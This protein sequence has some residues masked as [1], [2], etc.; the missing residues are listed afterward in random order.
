MNQCAK[1]IHV[2]TAQR[3]TPLVEESPCPS[4]A[5]VVPQ[6]SK[7][8]LEEVGTVWHMSLQVLE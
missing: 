5:V 3:V 4:G 6:L 2:A 8:L 1:A 7:G